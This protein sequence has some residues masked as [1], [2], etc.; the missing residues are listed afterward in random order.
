MICKTNG[1]VIISL[2]AHGR[3]G[4]FFLAQ[5]EPAGPAIITNQLFKWINET[6]VCQYAVALKDDFTIQ[7]VAEAGE[8]THEKFTADNFCKA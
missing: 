3:A 2:H 1:P 6:C 4:K 7:N 8:V 5:S